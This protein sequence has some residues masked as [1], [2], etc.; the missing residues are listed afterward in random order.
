EALARLYAH[1][2]MTDSTSPDLNLGLS[3]KVRDAS[4]HLHNLG[5]DI[6]HWLRRDPKRVKA[7]ASRPC[8]IIHL[9]QLDLI[10]GDRRIWQKF[11]EMSDDVPQAEGEGGKKGPG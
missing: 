9:H 5:K 4:H 3:G 2:V 10:S 6:L 8:D 7:G 11:R 1:N